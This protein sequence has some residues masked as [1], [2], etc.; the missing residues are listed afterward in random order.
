MSEQQVCQENLFGRDAQTG[1]EWVRSEGL[2]KYPIGRG[3]QTNLQTEQI[4]ESNVST[5]A[6][7]RLDALLNLS[8]AA[9]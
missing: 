5:G 1:R 7:L 4:W 2:S 3:A 8:D 9:R 6:Y